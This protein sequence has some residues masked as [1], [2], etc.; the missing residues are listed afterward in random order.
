MFVVLCEWV[1]QT[2]A[3]DQPELRV[4]TWGSVPVKLTDTIRL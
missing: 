3:D 2:G 1:L 4:T